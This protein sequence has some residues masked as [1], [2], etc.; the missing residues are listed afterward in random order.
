MADSNFLHEHMKYGRLLEFYLCRV[1]I[2]IFLN[3]A[4]ACTSVLL[5]C[6]GERAE[7]ISKIYRVPAVKIYTST[8][9]LDVASAGI[10]VI[11]TVFHL[12]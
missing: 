11:I 10:I 7:L 6:P 1:T 3:V 8:M 5:S 9:L 12:F 2:I 4:D